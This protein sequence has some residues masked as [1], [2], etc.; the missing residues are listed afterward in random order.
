VALYFLH[1]EAAV[2]IAC[3][4]VAAFGLFGAFGV[5]FAIPSAFL[6]QSQRAAGLA[7]ITTIGNLAGFVMPWVS[8][9]IQTGTAD[10]YLGM[11]IYGFVALA[12]SALPI[13]F[14]RDGAQTS[15]RKS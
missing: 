14:L 3:L 12:G 9:A 4:C 15:G 10:V 1:A 5:F 6:A 13:L 11:V 7:V 2:G 8:G